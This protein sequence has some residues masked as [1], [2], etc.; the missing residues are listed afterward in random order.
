M[1]SPLIIVRDIHQFPD[2]SGSVV[3]IGTFDGVHRGHQTIFQAMTQQARKLDMPTVVVT[4]SP[5]PR[6][7]LQQEPEKLHVLTTIHEKA[8]RVD[9]MGVDYLLVLRFTPEF[10]AIQPQDFVRNILVENLNARLLYAGYDHGFGKG[11][12]GNKHTLKELAGKHNLKIHQVPPLYHGHHII[13]SSIIRKHLVQGNVE[14]ARDMLGYP[15]EIT[16]E[17]V[18][19]NRLGRKIGF[20]TANIVVNDNLKLVPGI[21]VYAVRVKVGNT[22]YKGMLNIGKRPTLNTTKATV[23]AH[24]FDMEQD[25]YYQTITVQFVRFL[26]DERKF[27]GLTALRKQLDNDRDHALRVLKSK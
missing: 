23:E 10:A 14:A 16:G 26:R 2:F 9:S 6:L 11:K 25:I 27:P 21:G 17:V 19:G 18:E 22:W 4:F 12:K 3:A 5:H 13:S 8:T 7:V 24:L 20:P 15:Y 1:N